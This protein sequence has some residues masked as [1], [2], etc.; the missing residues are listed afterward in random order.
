MPA[1]GELC[2][3][4]LG[5]DS[6]VPRDNAITGEFDIGNTLSHGVQVLGGGID[7]GEEVLRF[8]RVVSSPGLSEAVCSRSWKLCYEM[9]ASQK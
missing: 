9:T 6:D 3:V 5:P 4:R 7:V 2:A 1:V 8:D